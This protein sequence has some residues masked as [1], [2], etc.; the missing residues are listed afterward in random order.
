L[1]NYIRTV[2]KK[3]DQNSF[4]VNARCNGGEGDALEDMLPLV[5]KKEV[6]CFLDADLLTGD[7]QRLLTQ[8]EKEIF[9]L[10]LEGLS[11]RE[12]GRRLGIS[13]AMIIK[14]E[15]RI[16]NKCKALKEEII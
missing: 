15:K 3:V 4:S 7:I 2:Y 8:R 1:K 13:H 11:I 9:H 10:S 12:I 14:I 6:T 16:R 5:D